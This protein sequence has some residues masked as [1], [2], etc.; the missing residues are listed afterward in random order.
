MALGHWANHGAPNVMVAAVDWSV[1]SAPAHLRAY[2]PVVQFVKQ[3]LLQQS[4]TTNK[5]NKKRDVD[6][7][8]LPRE[9]DP[10]PCVALVAT[11][12]LHDEEL[13]LN[14]RLNPNAAGG[15]PDWYSSIDEEEDARRWS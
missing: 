9:T 6:E 10:A 11:R 13:F 3:S 15:L 4:H 2:I 14:Y 12:P 5:E 8:F 7:M 1:H